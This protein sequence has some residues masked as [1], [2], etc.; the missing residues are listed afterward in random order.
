MIVEALLAAAPTP[1]PLTLGGHTFRL[2][3]VQG[4]TFDMGD[5]VGDLWD[6]CRPEH[7]VQL[8]DF[9]IGQFPV[10][11]ALWRAVA[12]GLDPATEPRRGSKPR[13][14]SLNPDPSFSKGDHRPVEQVSW[15]DA[16]VFLE[17]LNGL[18]PGWNFRLPTEAEWEYAARGGHHV[19]LLLGEGRGGVYYSG[20]DRLESV[21]W[22]PKNSQLETK[23]L[24]LK[25][26][27]GLGL[28]DM[29]GNVW[30]WCV[31]WF[32]SKFY[33]KCA[34]QGTVLN[35]RNDE[36]D[37]D[38]VVRGGSWIYGNKEDCRVAYRARHYPPGSSS[39]LG[40]RLS[41]SPSSSVISV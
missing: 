20:S 40:F 4:G 23:P 6:A 14:G 29:S 30:E 25:P 22:C 39:G 10:T 16:Q 15:D 34:D 1:I 33:E 19:A 26:P 36:R 11:Q 31:D 7:R 28:F 13:R 35:P 21:A 2:V 27:N 18:L 3:L 12:D 38:R 24:G 5:E 32:D 17:K 8:D 41:A 37:S 9:W